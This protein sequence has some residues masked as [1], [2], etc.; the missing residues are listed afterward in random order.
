MRL[1]LLA[2]VLGAA[3]TASA[4]TALPFMKSCDRELS[5]LSGARAAKALADSNS[6]DAT[7]KV[8]SAQGDDLPLHLAVTRATSEIAD[9]KMAQLN[10]A[11]EADTDARIAKADA[12]VAAATAKAAA[13]DAA[14]TAVQADETKAKAE[15]EQAAKDL[16]AAQQKLDACRR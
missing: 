14:L 2:V 3:V 4:C 10:G 6:L 1:T 9:A 13:A 12:D 7:A 15:A 5:S 16:T 11:S 8:L